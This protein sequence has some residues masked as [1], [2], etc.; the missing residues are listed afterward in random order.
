MKRKILIPVLLASAL[1]LSA[2][3]L[4]ACGGN[5]DPD[6]DSLLLHLTFDEGS[7]NTVKDD[8]G[9]QEDATVQYVFNDPVYQ[10]EPQ[11][12]QWRESGAVGGSLLFD[13]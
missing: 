9:K 12:P 13:G 8:A 10:H 6:K 7:G 4:A 11:D 1:A 2:A 3:G 5:N